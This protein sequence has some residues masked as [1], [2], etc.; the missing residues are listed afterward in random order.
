MYNI[1]IGDIYALRKLVKSLPY[2]EMRQNVNTKIKT[3]TGAE[4]NCFSKSPWISPVVKIQKMVFG[5]CANIIKRL[6]LRHSLIVF[7]KTRFDKTFCALAKVI[8][9][10]SLDYA[11]AYYQ[12]LLKSLNVNILGLL[13]M[14][15]NL[16]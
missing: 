7:V 11:I 16:R 3:L 9:F 8:M 4:I 5:K 12:V 1:Y 14:L 2:I 6:T 13:S 15:A 10:M